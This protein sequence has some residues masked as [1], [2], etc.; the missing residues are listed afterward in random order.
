MK[1]VSVSTRFPFQVSISNSEVTQGT[2]VVATIVLRTFKLNKLCN[3]GLHLEP[4]NFLYISNMQTVR[5]WFKWFEI[6]PKIM[7]KYRNW[8][9]NFFL[10]HKVA[11]SCKEI[12]LPIDTFHFL[13]WVSVELCLVAELFFHVL[14]G[15]A[16]S[17]SHS[18]CSKKLSTTSHL[19][20]RV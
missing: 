12:L 18:H 1:S 2:S 6:F 7:I 3:Q 19:F 9:W 14:E 17:L 8:K 4:F 11:F 15:L 10:S 20:H 13:P 5:P 16:L